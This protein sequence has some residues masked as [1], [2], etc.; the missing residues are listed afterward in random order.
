MHDD[1]WRAE[2]VRWHVGLAEAPPARLAG[3]AR[4]R[5][6]RGLRECRLQGTRTGRGGDSFGE[7]G[8]GLRSAKLRDFSKFRSFPQL[9]AIAF[10]SVRPSGHPRTGGGE[11]VPNSGF[12][13]VVF[14]G[15]RGRRGQGC[16]RREGTLR[17]GP[18]SGWAGGWRRLPKAAGGGYCRLQMPLNAA[19]GV[20][21][22]VAGHRLGALEGGEGRG[23][24]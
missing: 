7:G 12:C 24:D 22:P 9:S 2:G 10:C 6:L 14:S 16:I 15:G 8:G 20:R 17:G 19:L 5:P 21:G 13:A 4:C 18:S 11:P 3:T 23:Y 1:A